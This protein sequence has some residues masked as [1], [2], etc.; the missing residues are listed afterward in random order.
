M[1]HNWSLLS[2]FFAYPSCGPFS[3]NPIP[4]NKKKVSN[5]A[6]WSFYKIMKLI[7]DVNNTTDCI[8]FLYLKSMIKIADNNNKDRIMPH[9]RQNMERQTRSKVLAH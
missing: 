4:L 5:Y 7:L 3:G 6:S 2:Y 9:L 8:I 1:L